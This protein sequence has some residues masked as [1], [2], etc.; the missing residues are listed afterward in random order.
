MP[1]QPCHRYPDDRSLYQGL[2]LNETAAY[3]CLYVNTYA[4][5]ANY[6]VQRGGDRE[7]ARDLFQDGITRFWQKLQLGQYQYQPGT[8]I[9][10]V[11]FDYCKKRWI[12]FTRS[13]DF[14][15]V[16]PLFGDGD[17]SDDWTD[18]TEGVESRIIRGETLDRMR[19]CL[20]KMGER[21]RSVVTWFYMED[22]SLREIGEAL[23]T[24]ENAAKNARYECLEKL[25]KLFFGI[26]KP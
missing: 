24:S 3:E 4:S 13:T 21:C 25:K 8:Q 6:V 1:A 26:H 20:D 11:L 23:N 22:R 12:D 10:T 16:V 9:R 14:K 15:G 19:V 5:F 18:P 7:K 17:R 2:L